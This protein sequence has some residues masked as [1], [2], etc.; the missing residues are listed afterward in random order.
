ME[1]HC[2]FIWAD[3]I[4][5]HCLGI[6]YPR[7]E[8]QDPS[9]LVPKIFENLIHWALPSARVSKMTM[10]PT[11]QQNLINWTKCPLSLKNWFI[12]PSGHVFKNLIHWVRSSRFHRFDSLAWVGLVPPVSKATSIEF[13]LVWVRM[14]L[15]S[16]TW[17]I[18]S[19]PQGLIL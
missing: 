9:S 4:K 7:L 19:G 8:K 5:K 2:L 14:V 1:V 13:S 18:G 10:C 3:Y 15:V 11:V 6:V 16:K 17:P 12:G